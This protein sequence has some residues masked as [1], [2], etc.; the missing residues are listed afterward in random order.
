[1]NF[2]D[3]WSENGKI[4][5]AQDDKIAANEVEKADWN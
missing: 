4:K 2:G 5:R 1:M 3:I